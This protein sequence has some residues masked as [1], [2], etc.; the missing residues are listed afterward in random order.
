MKDAY[1]S[2]E[3]TKVSWY[4]PPNGISTGREDKPTTLSVGDPDGALVFTIEGANVGENDS[5]DD[6]DVAMD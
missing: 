6:L 5:N 4:S 1:E 3:S 2:N